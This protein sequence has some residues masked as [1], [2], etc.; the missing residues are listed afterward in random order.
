MSSPWAQH[1]RGAAALANTDWVSLALSLT[2]FSSPCS[3]YNRGVSFDQLR[4]FVSVA[5]EGAVRRAALKLHI[6]QPP[7]TRALRSLEE[8]LGAELFVRSPRGVVLSRAGERFLDHARR[9]LAEVE[10]ARS[11]V[12]GAPPS[13]SWSS[14]ERPEPPPHHGTSDG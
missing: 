6:S 12:R 1:A 5:E 13:V 10:A 11:A 3:R 8:E 4:Y 7:L 9:I 2:V 14:P